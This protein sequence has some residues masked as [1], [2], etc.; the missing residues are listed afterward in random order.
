MPT[1]HVFAGYPT[2]FLLDAPN[3]KGQKVQHLLWGD[4]CTVLGEKDGWLNVRGRGKNGWL[5]KEDTRKE[6]LLEVNFVDIGQGDGSFI[7]TPDDRFLVVDAGQGDNM[8]RFLRWRFNLKKHKNQ[9]IPI[10]AAVMSHPDSDHYA[11]FKFLVKSK[12]FRFK[13]VFHN[14][15]VERAGKDGLGVRIPKQQ[16]T[17][18]PVVSDLESLR[19]V[20][21]D[22]EDV[23][24][25]SYPALLGAYLDCA[26]DIRMLSS[27]DGF[28]PG[29]EEDK[30]L[31]LQ[32]LA[33]VPEQIEAVPGLRWFT[34]NGKTKNGHSVV[35]KLR[36]KKLTMLLGGD[37]NIPAEEYLLGHYTGIDAANGNADEVVARA[38]PHF[39]VEIA[40]ACH[41]GSADFS[42]AY[43]RAVNPLVTI[44]SSGDEEPH[45]H[46]R[47]DA[48]GAF[49]RYSRG[50]RPLIFSTEL[51]RSSKELIKDPTVLRMKLKKLSDACAAAGTPEERKAA[52]AKYDKALAEIERSVA[53][54]GM[55]TVRSDGDRVVIAQKLETARPNGDK[56][57]FHRFE[58]TENGEL[59]YQSKH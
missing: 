27:L 40:K 30:D 7:V 42:L 41:H 10:D 25:K 19:K 12:N 11:G 4:Y 56:W 43:L 55:I 17:H 36:Y 45:C 48:L 53:T 49:G 44:V 18:V 35:L 57:D 58:R 32:V 13:R 26:D 59:E 6:R 39:Q 15:I 31:S 46:P 54:Y 33:P 34:D 9:V 52:E 22:A 20:L 50:E 28:M 8:Y 16:R 37:L 38:R 3:A 1:E 21:A 23:G 5:R 51:A 14:G 2:A 47:P 24:T 29:Y